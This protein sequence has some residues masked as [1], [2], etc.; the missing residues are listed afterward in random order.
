MGDQALHSHTVGKDSTARKRHPFWRRFF[1]FFVVVVVIA[2]VV[3]AILPRVLRDYVNRT[4]DR[5][6]LY[7]GK[8]GELNIHLWRGAYSIQDISISKRTGNVPVPFFAGRR[9]E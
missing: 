3:R 5:N 1:I 9:V 4:L 7:S 2:S 6:Q 8:I